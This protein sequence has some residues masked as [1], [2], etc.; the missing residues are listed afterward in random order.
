MIT[1]FCFDLNEMKCHAHNEIKMQPHGD[2]RAF[3]STLHKLCSGA[4]HCKSI[5]DMLFELFVVGVSWF[6]VVLKLLAS[7]EDTENPPNRDNALCRHAET[8]TKNGF[9]HQPP[10]VIDCK[11]NSVMPLQWYPLDKI[12][13][14]AS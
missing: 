7:S 3:E 14:L 2:L 12:A 9:L 5:E 1:R 6:W 8:T 11:T 10:S 4:E 13:C